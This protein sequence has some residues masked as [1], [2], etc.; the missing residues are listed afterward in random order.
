MLAIGYANAL[1]PV[2]DDLVAAHRRAWERLARPGTWWSGAERVAIAA[3]VR[4]AAECAL[5]RDR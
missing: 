5:C 3:D 4:S 2:R 1:V